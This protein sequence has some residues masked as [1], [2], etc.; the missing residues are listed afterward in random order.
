MRD[1]GHVLGSSIFEVWLK[2]GE[3]E[4]KLVFSGDLG[5][6]PAPIVKD[7]ELISGADVVFV[8]STYGNRLHEPKEKG[9]AIL[10]REIEKVIE[11]QGVLMVPV[12]ALERTQELLYELNSL[13]ESK[14]IPYIPVFLDSP[15]AVKTTGIYKRYSDFYDPEAKTLIERG[16]DMF[17][18]KGLL[19]INNPS[20]SGVAERAI[21][22]KII[23]AG[24][25]M[26]EGG[27]IKRYLK[28]YLGDSSN[29][30][31]TISYQPESSLGKKLINGEKE[32]EV[33]GKKI[34]VKAEIAVILSFSS[35]S[36]QLTL[37][38]WVDAMNN[39]KPKKV[40]VV[41]GDQNAGQSFATVLKGVIKSDVIVPLSGEKYEF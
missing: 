3:K 37:L 34:N 23:L 5:N 40:F 38:N 29:T 33:E 2:D 6:P 11:K 36:D 28:A 10:K 27:R 20:Q 31:L 14:K 32:V 25:G 16:D 1:A 24:S 26:F 30:L 19:M 13:I 41:H 8:E 17:D 4:R 15:L 39:P 35:H 22:P 12:F 7:P 18:F 9:L 21:P